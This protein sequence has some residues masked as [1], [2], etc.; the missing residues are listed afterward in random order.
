MTRAEYEKKK[1]ELEK[2]LE[3]LEKEEIIDIRWKPNIN[4]RYYYVS[5]FG[6]VHSVWFN[7]D[8]YDEWLYITGNCFKTKEE[9]EEYRKKL[10]TYYK[11]KN[12]IEERNEPIDWENGDQ[13]KWYIYVDFC[14][15]INIEFDPFLKQQGTIYATSE[16]LIK[17]A[18]EY[19]GEDNIKKYILEVE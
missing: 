18:I 8:K 1:A 13:E 9:A 7:D 6:V 14:K 12:Y 4:K 3:E 10:E 11:F 5:D 15:N 2:Q 17:D 16:Q 19:V